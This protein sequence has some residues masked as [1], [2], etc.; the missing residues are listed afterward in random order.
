MLLCTTG[1][2]T[3]M[4]HIKPIYVFVLLMVLGA[5]L[6]IG[7]YDLGKHAGTKVIVTNQPMGMKN[8]KSYT[9]EDK[10]KSYTESYKSIGNIVLLIGGIGLVTVIT[11]EK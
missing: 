5:F 1:G 7:S 6:T 4:Q 10:I 2:V 11:K 8:Y 9:D 3:T